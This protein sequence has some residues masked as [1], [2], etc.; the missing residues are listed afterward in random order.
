VWI[1]V[2]GFGLVIVLMLVQRITPTDSAQLYREAMEAGEAGNRDLMAQRMEQLRS[3]PAYSA[4]VQFLD[5]LLFLGR[6]MPLKAIPLLSKAAEN[7]EVR[8]KALVSL[9]R[10]YG[11]AGQLELAIQTLN[12]ISDDPE[13]GNQARFIACGMLATAQAW[14]AAVEQLRM[15]EKAGF[16][17]PKVLHQLAEIEFDRGNYAEAEKLF[18]AAIDAFPTDPTNSMKATR[19]LDCRL[20]LGTLAGSDKYIDMLDNQITSSMYRAE[21]LMAAGKSKEARAAV[22]RGMREA[23]GNPALSFLR[24]KLA[25][26]EKSAE[27]AKQVLP[28]VMVA[29]VQFP[30]AL[31]GMRVTA[32][33]AE[34]AGDADL[35]D[36]ARRNVEGIEAIRAQLRDLMPAVAKSLV[37][38]EVRLQMA[39]LARE[40][41]D[42]DLMQK[43]FRGLML[44]HPELEGELAQRR[45]AMDE[46]PALLVPF[47]RD[48]TLPVN[49]GRIDNSPP[50]GA[51]LQSPPVPP[52]PPIRK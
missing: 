36:K 31:D 41:G 30:R 7:P 24:G 19:L 43:V 38:V 2:G 35:A 22:D 8:S 49:R 15:L 40:C 3:D 48:V 13:T 1:V 52:I 46:A 42:S 25:L 27:A 50:P 51:M 21:A 12:S 11:T 23:E 4:H 26:A 17:T 32:Q 39:A 28:E 45:M 44:F 5:G 29:S 16:E 37:D 33:L 10:A 18:V 20:Q 6:S 47:D 9:G 34:L 14:D